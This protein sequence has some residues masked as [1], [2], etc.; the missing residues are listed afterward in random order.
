VHSYLRFVSHVDRT[1]RI[2]NSLK[3]AIA[4]VPEWTLQ[5]VDCPRLPILRERSVSAVE[6]PVMKRA[7]RDYQVD[8]ESVRPD[9]LPQRLQGIINEHLLAGAARW[10][11]VIGIALKEQPQDRIVSKLPELMQYMVSTGNLNR[12]SR[13]YREVAPG[14]IVEELEVTK[15]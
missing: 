8:S 10:S 14:F 11:D 13:Q 7:R 4:V 2:T 1:R 9:Q 15:K 12:E 5:V 3:E 6:R